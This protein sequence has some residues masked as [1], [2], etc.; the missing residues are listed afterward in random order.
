VV[1]QV[2]GTKGLVGRL[3]KGSREKMVLQKLTIESIS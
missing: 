3:W 2:E 1:W